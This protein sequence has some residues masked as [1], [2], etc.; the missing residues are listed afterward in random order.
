MKHFIS[1]A[2]IVSVSISCVQLAKDFT[3]TESAEE[4]S[5]E[6]INTK[7][8]TSVYFWYKN[9][10]IYLSQV[11]NTYF[12]IFNKG[13]NTDLEQLAS[14]HSNDFELKEFNLE[15]YTD[16]CGQ[17][18]FMS[19]KIT[20]ELADEYS[21]SIVYMAPY[22]TG[23][24]GEIGITDRFYIKLKSENDI[25]LLEAFADQNGAEIIWRNFI[26][27]WYTL[28]CGQ[29]SSGNA[30]ELA[31]KAYESGLFEMTDI[32]FM[33]DAEWSSSTYYN[34]TYYS[35]DQ[36]NLHGTYGIDI[37]NVHSITKGNPSVKV[38]I[39]DS[40]IQL[41]HPD[42]I[43]TESWDAQTRKSPG[44]LYFIDRE[45][46]PHGTAMTGIIG[47]TTNNS[48]GIAGIAP[49]ISLLPM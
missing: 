49:E 28:V 27:L 6:D 24:G 37:E 23:Y 47:A 39:V 16:T 2:A 31:N 22:L 14:S 42:L 45:A 44:R 21:E 12:A 38:A 41:N 8:T 40:G 15:H 30:L 48:I 10:K 18:E 36:W 34:D 32:E 19:A 33:D 9:E 26:P 25:T 35:T 43:V 46:H 4:L 11:E 17:D 3:L 5:H 1:I 20:H 29:S 7:S 13:S